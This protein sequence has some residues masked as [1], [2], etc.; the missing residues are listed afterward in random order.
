MELEKSPQQ[1]EKL[2]GGFIL[3]LVLRFKLQFI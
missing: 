3:R 1:F 2:L